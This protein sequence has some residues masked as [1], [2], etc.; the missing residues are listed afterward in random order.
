MNK[1]ATNGN[2]VCVPQA[3]T[4]G[5]VPQAAFTPGNDYPTTPHATEGVYALSFSEVVW[6]VPGVNA[7][8]PQVPGVN[9]WVTHWSPLVSKS[10]KGRKRPRVRLSGA[11]LSPGVNAR[12]TE[13]SGC[14]LSDSQSVNARP[15]E[16]RNS[17]R[18]DNRGGNART[19]Q[20]LT[21]ETVNTFSK[22]IES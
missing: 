22:T 20:I 11:F 16:F 10:V 19:N 9:A 6:Q 8:V 14:R 2:W 12:P 17:R 5:N 15:T 7:W 18:P 4:P 13:N 21:L 1:Q 3:F